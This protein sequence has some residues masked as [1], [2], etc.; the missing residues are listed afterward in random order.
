M[1]V[2]SE[3]EKE[4]PEGDLRSKEPQ[5]LLTQPLKIRHMNNAEG[6]NHE[7]T[8]ISTFLKFDF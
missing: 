1:L 8:V 6:K 7:F 3:P 4:C 5:G 2:K